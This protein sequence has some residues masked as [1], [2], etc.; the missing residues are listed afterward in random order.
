MR[1][2]YWIFIL[3]FA[4]HVFATGSFSIRP[5]R[6]D[7]EEPLYQ[8]LC[9]VCDLDE[10]DELDDEHIHITRET[11]HRYGFS[12]NPY[13]YVEVAEV[14]GELVGCAVY[15]Y[16]FYTCLG[17]PNLYIEDLYIKPEF[18]GQGIGTALFKQLI[19]YAKERECAWVD[20]HVNSK[21]NEA[22]RFYKKFG[23]TFWGSRLRYMTVDPNDFE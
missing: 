20:W 18:R 3:G 12:Q 13:F 21:D 5:V 8:L 11:L 14:E 1:L 19:K 17:F 4:A 10:L 2:C 15:Y 7:E 6:A 9:E 22:I 23:A 16:T